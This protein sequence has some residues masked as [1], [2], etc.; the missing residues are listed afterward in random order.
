MICR[1]K[2]KGYR[3]IS[4]L[5]KMRVLP[6]KSMSRI[7]LKNWSSLEPRTKLSKKKTKTSKKNSN[8]L[9]LNY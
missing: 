2:S 8:R 3:I 5:N 6:P 4:S 9:K 7:S 1:Q